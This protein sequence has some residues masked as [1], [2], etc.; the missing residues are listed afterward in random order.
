M[1]VAYPLP[2]GDDTVSD[3]LPEAR[4]DVGGYVQIGIYASAG[5]GAG[6]DSLLEQFARIEEAGFHTAW[7]GQTFEFEALSVL[8]L[9]GRATSR[10]EL[11]SW[12]V[13]MHP[14]HP[15]AL[16]QLA[17]TAQQACRGRLALGIGVSH[18]AVIEGRFGLDYSHPRPFA[19]EYVEVLTALMNGDAVDHKGARFEIHARLEPAV[20]RPPVLLAALGP[21]MLALAGRAT[22]GA[23]IW[24]GGPRYLEE[25]AIPTLLNTAR[26][27]DRN[28]PRV[29]CGLPIAI[30]RE[31]EAARRAADR[32]L[33]ASSKLPAYRNVLELEGVESA[34]DVALI[35]EEIEVL[36]ALDQLAA[37]GVTDFN[38]VLFPIEEDRAAPRRTFEFLSR[39]ARLS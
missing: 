10:V 3:P 39:L 31:T 2:R 38:A 6:L 23:A 19:Q 1:R 28:A 18:A 22:D 14:R 7:L 5:D 8:A 24:L 25:F 30:T 12:V 35:G 27:A 16:A 11:G 20:P 17:A 13:P 9:A 33:A 37:L 36:D 4:G 15:T 21:Q 26:E 29:A 34:A 32:F